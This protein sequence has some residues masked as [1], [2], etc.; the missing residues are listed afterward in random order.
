M[1][2]AGLTKSAALL[3]VWNS[4]R[5]RRMEGEQPRSRSGVQIRNGRKQSGSGWQDSYDDGHVVI[6]GDVNYYAREA[7]KGGG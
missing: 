6:D 2:R 5:A 3:C 7:G 4:G 1:C